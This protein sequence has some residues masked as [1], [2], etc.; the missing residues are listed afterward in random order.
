M[1]K[2]KVIYKSKTKKKGGHRMRSK[3]TIPLG[4]L[5]G[6]LPGV[7]D[8]F[9]RGRPWN[10]GTGDDAM[11]V[12]LGG[13]TGFQ[14]HGAASQYTGG[15]SWSPWRLNRGLYPLLAGVGF[16]IVLGKILGLNRTLSRMRVP[17]VRI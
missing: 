16:H 4:L 10:N 9:M 8:A 13:Y 17:L 6:L 15:K 3:L 2:K 12:L 11:S 7:S 1:A 14:T 5:M